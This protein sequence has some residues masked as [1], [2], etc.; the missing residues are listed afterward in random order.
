MSLREALAAALVAQHE[1]TPGE[2]SDDLQK[3]VAVQLP[4]AI[5]AVVGEAFRVKGSAGVGNQAEIPWVSV[6]PPDVRSAR[7]GRYVVYL[8]SAS[9]SRVFLSLSQAVTG[10]AKAQLGG[11][12]EDLRKLAGEQ[13]DVLQKIELEATGDLGHKYEL[14]TAYALE[15]RAEMMPS[16]EQLEADLRRFLALLEG[17]LDDTTTMAAA[18]LPEADAFDRAWLLEQ[19]NWQADQ[20]ETLRDTIRDGSTQIVLAG[21]PGTSKT[22]VA[23][24]ILR[25]LTSGDPARVR[26]VQFHPSYSYEDFIEG[27]RPVVDKEGRVAF[28]PVAGEVLRFVADIGMS[29]ESHLL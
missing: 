9:G 29:P 23:K 20:L 3:A 28:Q 7:E 15:Y 14:A 24:A 22:W 26:I 11:L 10:H 27:L 17:V 21:P 25:H 2:W 18:D 12:A 16:Q 1:R 6:M 5:R 4:N 13:A 19:T 8:F